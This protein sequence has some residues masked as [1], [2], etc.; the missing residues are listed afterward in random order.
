[1]TARKV[2]LSIKKEKKK[3]TAIVHFT[4]WFVGAY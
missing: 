3:A 1:M 2:G 4:S